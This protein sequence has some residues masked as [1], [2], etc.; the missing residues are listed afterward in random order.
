M[1]EN[2]SNGITVQNNC[3]ECMVIARDIQEDLP[4]GKCQ[5]CEEREEANAD[6]NAWNLHEDDRL[7]E[8]GRVMT[9]DTSAPPSASDWIASETVGRE[10]LYIISLEIIKTTEGT[11]IDAEGKTREYNENWFHIEEKVVV[12]KREEDFIVR[13]EY[14]PPIVQLVDGGVHEE[15]WELDDTRQ[16]EREVVC[17][18]CHLLTVKL[19]NDCQSCDKPLELNVR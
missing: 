7:G 8:P 15:L 13:N 3:Y 6:D 12:T 19:Y 16:R 9:Y 4:V 11:Y 17:Q 1:S 5:S 14:L 18:W 2:M 10:S